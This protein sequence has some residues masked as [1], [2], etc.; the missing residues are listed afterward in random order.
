MKRIALYILLAGL[1]LVLTGCEKEDFAENEPDAAAA[2]EMNA[3]EAASLVEDLIN[4]WNEVDEEE[5]EGSIS[6]GDEEDQAEAETE[7]EAEAETETDSQDKTDSGKDDAEQS[8]PE[9]EGS[10]EAKVNIPSSELSDET[11]RFKTT[12]IDN[13]VV[14]QDIFSDY[15]I[16]VVWVWGTYC[17]TCI[18]E[19]EDYAEFYKSLPSN[20]NLIGMVF[21]VYDGIDN[22]VQ[23]AKEYLGDAGAEFMNLRVSDDLYGFARLFQYLP[24]GFLVDSEGHIIG[25]IHE[26]AGVDEM[27]QILKGYLE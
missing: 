7:A 1:L 15:D 12:T 23:E 18:S 4:I 19:M 26:G 3:E 14:S 20:V 16:T 13:K 25:K 11:L 8:S 17:S 24:S 5:T 21:D 9:K 6:D 2:E 22:N 27:K 10:G